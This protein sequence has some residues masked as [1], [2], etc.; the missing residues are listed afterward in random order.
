MFNNAII[1]VY[2][3]SISSCKSTLQLSK[4]YVN[5]ATRRTAPVKD[6]MKVCLGIT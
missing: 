2:I 1:C 6:L 5:M 3:Y 4:F